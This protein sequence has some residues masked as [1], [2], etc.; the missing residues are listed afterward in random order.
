MPSSGL[1]V[2]VVT[3]GIPADEVVVFG[4]LALSMCT[5]WVCGS[6]LA[7]LWSGGSLMISERCRGQ[8]PEVPRLKKSVEDQSSH[9]F[10]GAWLQ[11]GPIPGP[12]SYQWGDKTIGWR[13]FY[14]FRRP[15]LNSSHPSPGSRPHS[16]CFV[17]NSKAPDGMSLLGRYCSQ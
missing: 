15:Y 5:V 8:D 16:K 11:P 3:S 7:H 4:A 10:Q 12:H 6:A 13:A 9:A 17:S 1:G 14:S 2:A